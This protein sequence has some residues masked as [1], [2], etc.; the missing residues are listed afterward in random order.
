MSSRR[1]TGK[2]MNSATQVHFLYTKPSL[3]W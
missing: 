1:Q 2:L 3:K